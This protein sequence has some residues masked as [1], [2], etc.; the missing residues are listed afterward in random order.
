MAR[1]SVI[2]QVTDIEFIDAV[3]SSSTQTEVL[4]KFGLCNRGN[5]YRTLMRRIREL[6][7][8][9]SHF[10]AQNANALKKRTIPLEAVLI[11]N[12]QY[13]NT[14]R[15]K[16]RLLKEQLIENV[17]SLCGL[18]PYWNGRELALQLDHINGNHLDNRIENIRILCPNCHSQTD[19]F[20]GKSKIGI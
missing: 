13:S 12:S 2:R 9:T 1:K 8:D 5:N 10:L 18:T 6:G 16:R 7:I 20:A 11:Q 19:T 3:K 17:C 4:A 15:L 14:W